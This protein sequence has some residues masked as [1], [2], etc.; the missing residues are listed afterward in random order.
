MRP[1]KSKLVASILAFF[2][3][4]FGLHRF[5]LGEYQTGFV[6]VVMAIMFAGMRFPITTI[7]GFVEFFRLLSM[8]QS[9]FDRRYNKH[10]MHQP[11]GRKRTRKQQQS[12]P[13]NYRRR[14]NP[15]KKNGFKKYKEYDIEGAIDDLEEALKIDPNDK[16]I[17][18]KL[19][20]GYSLMEE[21]EEALNYLHH[22]IHELGYKDFE[23]I[24]S[25]DDLAYLRIS[26]VFQAYKANG[27]SPSPKAQLAAPKKDLLQDDM[28]L[29]QLKKLSE[30][31][32]RG[33][34]SDI[35]FQK[36]KAK[37]LRK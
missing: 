5:Y 20:C 14:E 7:I 8:G 2:G 11:G 10:L 15:Y 18:F 12:Q 4:S 29:S 1:R 9:E 17:Y 19:A 37:L 3:G 27:Y 30:L 32:A 6:F 16:E 22:A 35:D 13:T 21:P 26:P 23:K 36:E 25:I 24:E 28:L 34:L 33:L 31:K